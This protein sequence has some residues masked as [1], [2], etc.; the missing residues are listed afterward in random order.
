MEITH[1]KIEGKEKA[2]AKEGKEDKTHEHGIN[3]AKLDIWLRTVDQ[4]R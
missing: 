1:H 4:R 3:V 2:Q